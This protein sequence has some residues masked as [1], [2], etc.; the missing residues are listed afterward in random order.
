MR[1]VLCDEDRLVC[2]I[3]E[4]LVASCGHEVAGV[5]HTTTDAYNLIVAARP[6]AVIVDLSL[7]YNTDFDVLGIT[8][9]I[10]AKTIVFSLNADATLLSRYAVRPVFVPKPDFVA[11]EQAIVEL[12]QA[13]DSAPRPEDRRKRPA[14]ALTG[15]T[16]RG[17]ADAGAFF[18]ALNQAT[19]GDALVSIDLPGDSGP[20]TDGAALGA[21]VVWEIRQ[22]D[23]LLGSDSWVRIFLA[24]AGP[25]GAGVVLQ[26]LQD[27]LD[28]PSGAR[29]RAIVIQPGESAADA[30][31]R[32][33]HS[34]D[35][36][37]LSV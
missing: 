34:E 22:T 27:N 1:F 31:D 37:R 32:L 6:D 13:T 28:L 12:G 25:D 15:A 23:R 18:E 20:A 4:T 21:F 9:E 14:R 35:I 19:D 36:V 5:A 16:P 2:S 8:A 11:L 10:G 3:V 29:L 30:F 26:R 7:G 24:G 17:P 33:K